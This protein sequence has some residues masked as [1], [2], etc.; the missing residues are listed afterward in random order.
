MVNL[1]HRAQQLISIMSRRMI[2]PCIMNQ[3]SGCL[4]QWYALN[5]FTLP[6]LTK[7][8]RKPKFVETCLYV[9][10]YQLLCTRV[11][12][13]GVISETVEAAKQLGYGQLKWCG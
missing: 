8:L 5:K 4:R 9:G 7:S 3:Y 6:L 13:H 11:A 2:V 10:L 1:W 12:P